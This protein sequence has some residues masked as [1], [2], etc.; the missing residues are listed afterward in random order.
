MAV[1]R[2]VLAVMLLVCST[3]SGCFQVERVVTVHP[4]GSA[5]IDETFLMSKKALSAMGEAFGDTDGKKSG[6]FSLVKEEQ[7]KSAAANMGEGVSYIGSEK[8]SNKDYAGY[9]ATY[10]IPDI[11]KLLISSGPP[12]VDGK[13]EPVDPAKASRFVFTPGAAAMLLIKSPQPAVKAAAGEKPAATG[14]A[15][16][17]KKLPTAAEMAMMK[18]MFDGMRFAFSVKVDGK[19][20][21]TNA[22]Y[23]EKST[24]VLADVDFG[25]LLSMGPEELVRLNSAKDGEMSQVLK[26]LRSFPGVKVDLNEEVKIRFGK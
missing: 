23:R 26:L 11:N 20:I 10:R 9:R 4:D 15:P 7:L 3:L 22:T 21:E 24:V 5:T 6:D 25:K 14:A 16:E 17:P 8:I 13:Q 19:I 1:H 18:Q 12:K 2:A